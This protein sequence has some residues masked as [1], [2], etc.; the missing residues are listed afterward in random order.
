MLEGLRGGS[1]DYLDMVSCTLVFD[2][3][4]TSV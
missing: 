4:E 3:R 2:T 1:A